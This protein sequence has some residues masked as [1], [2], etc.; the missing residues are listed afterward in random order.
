MRF[1]RGTLAALFFSMALATGAT[2]A[3]GL[4]RFQREIRPQLDVQKFTYRSGEAL[5]NSG[6]ILNDVVI[7]TPPAAPTA[8]RAGTFRI[9]KVTVEALDFDRLTGENRNDP[10]RF[11]KMKIEGLTGDDPATSTLSAYGIPKAPIDITF[12]YRFDR[13]AMRMNIDKLE[14][15]MRGEGRLS[16]VLAIAG[17]SDVAS[18]R[19]NAY[20]ESGTIVLEDKGF[21]AK[22]LETFARGR[23]NTP[24]GLVALSLI[25]LSGIASQQ[26]PETVRALDAIASFI[27]DWKAPKGPLTIGLKG[28]RGTNVDGLGAL[29]EADALY[30][31]LGL[32]A[33]YA[34]TRP[35][36]ALAGPPLQ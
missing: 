12:D 33:S 7:V 5:G 16:A 25:T 18:A 24:E 4:E 23:G 8:N 36:A 21:M 15:A 11:V 10:P 28:P 19:Q 3:D 31:I 30:K 2:A 9:D 27:A 6:F 35:G 20:L 17:F 14:I 1:S 32:S 13:G 34:G 29:L 26:R 22:V